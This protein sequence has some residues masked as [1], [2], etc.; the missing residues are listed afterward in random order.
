MTV[1]DILARVQAFGCRLVEV[2]GGEPLAQPGVENFLHVLCDQDYEVLLETSGA[3]DV[4]SLDPRLHLIL[5]VKCPG[6]GMT[7]RMH[8][9]NLNCLTQKDDVK[10]VISHR[11]DYD[12]AV[13]VLQRH[14]L[15]ERCGVL[16]SPV[17]GVLELRTL[18]E[19]ILQDSLAVRFQIQL[20]KFIWT[21][22]TRGV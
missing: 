6:S 4:S 14:H 17:F 5:D 12:W 2:T 21:P 11:Q 18:A 1:P 3:L 13:E 15:P 10:F 9:E 20:H 8:W 19:W 22:N 7:E 16:F